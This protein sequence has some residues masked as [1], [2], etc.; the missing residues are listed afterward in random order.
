MNHNKPHFQRVARIP[1]MAQFDL[2]R[3][4][5]INDKE[6][7]IC[8]LSKEVN[9]EVCTNL[10]CADSTFSLASIAVYINKRVS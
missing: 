2:V 5:T 6:N 7:R 3:A 1:H 8:Q 9:A 10:L 4:L